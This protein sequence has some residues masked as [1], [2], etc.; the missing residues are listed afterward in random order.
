MSEQHLIATQ[1]VYLAAVCVCLLDEDGVGGSHK[2]LQICLCV[3]AVSCSCHL[4]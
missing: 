4:E 1:V 3:F 2:Y